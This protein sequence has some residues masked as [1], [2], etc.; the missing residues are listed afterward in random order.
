MPDV[1]QI[2]SDYVERFAA[3]DPYAATLAG[4][5]GHDTEATDY[6]PEA[7]AARAELDRR[8][9]QRL[10]TV[11][12]ATDAERIAREV[13]RER[14]QVH[15]DG[16]AALDHLRDLRSLHSPSGFPRQVFDL[17]PRETEADWSAVNRRLQLV[18]EA[19]RR[20]RA[21]L[22]EGLSQGISA[23]ARQAIEVA[24]Q[25]DVWGGREGPSFFHRMVEVYADPQSALGRSLNSGADVAARAYLELA[26]Y[27]RDRY[28]AR[29]TLTDGVGRERYQ[30]A[31]RQFTGMDLDLDETYAWGWDELHRVEAEMARVADRIL[32][33]AGVPAV[34]QLLSTDPERCLVGVE[35]FQAWLQELHDRA[36]SDLDGV[37][38]EVPDAVR[39][40]QVTIPPP[41]GPLAAYYTPPSEDLTR[42]G[43][44]WWPV[45]ST[46]VF[47]KWD[48]V[49]TAFHEG[50]PGHHFELGGSRCLD[51]RLTRFQKTLG[52]ISG[53]GEGWALYAERLMGELGY[54]ENPDYELGM[55]SAQAL[56]SV[57]VIVDIGLHL[58][59]RIPANEA[60]HP[61]E[62]WT[63]DLAVE[64]AIQR[65]RQARDFMRSEILRYLGWPGQAISY[66]VGEREWLRARD[67]ARHRQGPA[68]NLKEFHTTALN[69]GPLSLEMLGPEIERA[70][71]PSQ[72]KGRLG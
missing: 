15:L 41:G 27:L 39:R 33:G 14:L 35:A 68:F 24:R 23:A 4:L 22:D 36:I 65:T 45:G 37:H 53:Y 34:A 56:R 16:Y 40:V 25:A 69:L 19:L 1:F 44:T 62:V 60:F 17:M 12:I 26:A 42:P 58:G 51:E 32:P 67:S 31:A 66:K 70:V 59:L 10:A 71:L 55:L 30:L 29:A 52:W 9:L 54:L 38:F 64:F 49:T 46:T 61:G 21:S 7:A 6:S 11:P 3:L 47:P 57:R 2:A 20:Y 18:P 43:R 72:S 13:M 50:V 28:S 63:H 8:T 48:R 5:P